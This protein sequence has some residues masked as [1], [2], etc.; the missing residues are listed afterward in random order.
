MA[1]IELSDEGEFSDGEK[2][3]DEDNISIDHPNTKKIKTD[4][5]NNFMALADVA[6]ELS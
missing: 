2:D 4:N 3:A 1:A 5:K 6:L